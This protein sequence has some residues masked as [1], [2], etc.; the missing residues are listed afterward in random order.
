MGV[1]RKGDSR[2]SQRNGFDD[3]RDLRCACGGR[4]LEFF[5]GGDVEKE[6]ADRDRR[7]SI[8]GAR[9]NFLDLPSR[10]ADRRSLFSVG[11]FHLEVGNGGDR[12]ES[13]ASEAQGG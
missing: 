6:G 12:R 2:M 13:L 7:P 8:A 3:P 10:G 5:P 4:F 11:G 9:G 1:E